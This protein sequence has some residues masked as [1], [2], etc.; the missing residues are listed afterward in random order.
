MES[1]II[2]YIDIISFQEE[3]EPANPL[4]AAKTVYKILAVYFLIGN[5]APEFRN[6]VENIN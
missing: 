4:G 6:G 1:S 5:L 3:F 2:R